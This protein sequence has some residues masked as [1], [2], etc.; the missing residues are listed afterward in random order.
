M[1]VIEKST[2]FAAYYAL[3][4]P[5]QFQPRD[6]RRWIL[7]LRHNHLKVVTF[8][9]NFHKVHRPSDNG[10]FCCEETVFLRFPSASRRAV[11][12]FLTSLALP[13]QGLCRADRACAPPNRAPDNP[14]GNER[15]LPTRSTR[16]AVHRHRADSARETVAF[17]RDA[18]K[19]DAV[20]VN[21]APPSAAR[22]TWRRC[23]FRPGAARPHGGR[24]FP[25]VLGSAAKAPRCTIR[26]PRPPPKLCGK[27]VKPIRSARDGGAPQ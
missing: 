22:H 19:P 3:T 24:V 27:S 15:A 6:Q 2:H 11:H 5:D 13:R 16:V 14:L 10:H 20:V 4:S 23:K 26:H 7:C 25:A 1:I 8:S 18:R 12:S 9:A 17:A 21:A